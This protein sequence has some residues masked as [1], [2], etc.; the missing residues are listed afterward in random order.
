MANPTPSYLEVFKEGVL[1]A[2]KTRTWKTLGDGDGKDFQ[3]LSK[4]CPFFAVEFAGI[5]LRNIRKHWGPINRRAAEV[6]ADAD[7]LFK[8]VQKLV[9]Q[10]QARPRFSSYDR[11]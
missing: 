11:N 5:G 3:K 6:K 8:E 10:G 7:S 9:D 1:R 2:S 4:D